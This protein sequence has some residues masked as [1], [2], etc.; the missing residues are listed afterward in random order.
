MA[1][2]VWI[3][4]S[5]VI[6]GLYPLIAYSASDIVHPVFMVALAHSTATLVQFVFLFLSAKHQSESPSVL[7]RG[8]LGFRKVKVWALSQGVVHSFAHMSLFA[9]FIYLDKYAAALVYDAW[10]ILMILLLPMLLPG[11]KF[12]NLRE[13]LFIG[14]SFTGLFLILSTKVDI[15]GNLG[16]IVDVY[17]NGSGIGSV[18]ALLSMVGMAFTAGA[19]V[20]LERLI[21]ASYRYYSIRQIFPTDNRGD[22]E[23]AAKNPFYSVI[24]S[25]FLGNASSMVVSVAIASLFFLY[26]PADAFTKSSSSSIALI[27]IAAGVIAATAQICFIIANRMTSASSINVL[28][29]LT[30]LFGILF[31]YVFGANETIESR[32]LLGG[33]LVISANLALSV[34]SEITTAYS[35]S[36]AS[37]CLVAVYCY[38]VPGSS[39]DAY[40]AA[41]G[42]PAGIFAILIAFM[43][44]RLSVRQLRQE[45]LAIRI[46]EETGNKSLEAD[47]E[48]YIRKTVYEILVSKSARYIRRINQL[49][50]DH[51]RDHA[52]EISA[53]MTRLAANRM[54]IFGFG[55][56]FVLWLIGSTTLALAIF[57]RPD[58]I[59]SNLLAVILA[60]TISFLCV[61]IVEPVSPRRASLLFDLVGDNSGNSGVQRKKED[62]TD[63]VALACISAVFSI[64]LFGLFYL[65]LAGT[66]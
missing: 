66:M 64:V 13:V 24:M 34:Q 12:P 25:S 7:I 46:V 17:G 16:S 47:H 48:K 40:Y 22:I 30:P 9:A 33:M 29:N 59:E 65:S 31:L 27:G 52:P 4:V 44:E 21:N 19:A 10:P 58:R 36:I 5:T 61:L 35:V 3:L 2:F 54:R 50:I 14:V 26:S 63:M 60:A 37:I 41:I 20:K 43:T 42:V 15:S 23:K 38:F 11:K 32:I 8:A 39:M 57:G 45:D 51:N 6:Y 28:F 49:F 18:I 55:E 62:E 56:I 1:P 53:L